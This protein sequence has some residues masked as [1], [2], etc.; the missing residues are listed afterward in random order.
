MG[1]T[2][3]DIFAKYLLQSLNSISLDVGTKPSPNSFKAL[4]VNVNSVSLRSLIMNHVLEER[5]KG[6]L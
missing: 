5:W 1:I 6:K 2:T 3:E 4:K